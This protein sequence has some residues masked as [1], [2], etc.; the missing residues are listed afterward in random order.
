M[1]LDF[2]SDINK[3]ANYAIVTLA[4]ALATD[5]ALFFIK[6]YIGLSSN[7]L[8]ILSDAIN[9]LSDTFACAIAIVSFAIIKKNNDGRLA[10]GYGR[11]E[12]VADFMM[13]V[14][15]CI[16]G[17]AFVYLAVERLILPSIMIF[18]WL[19]FG[20]VSATALVKVGLGFFFRYRNKRVDSGVLRASEL[21]SFADAGI[22]V[23]S[24]IGFAL[25]R[26]AKLRIDAVFGLIISGIMI[27]NGIKLLIHSV[28]TLL[29]E[30][31]DKEV[32]EEIRELCKA[33]ES[34]EQIREINV[35]RYGA[36]YTELV[37]N[38]VFTSGIN[39]DIIVKDVE[40]LTAVLKEKYGFEPK[41]CISR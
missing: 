38:A 14:I 1:K 32:C 23:M 17:F 35:H 37:V 27:F 13:S 10:Y 5:L 3:R 36:G 6:L 19:Y 28:K 39:Y 2:I 11:M 7:S 12:Y 18:S 25:N 30:K 8:A 29:G 20:I 41:I 9:N 4:V 22:T 31:L 15:I 16:V 40:D 24:L 33:Y 26:Y 21:D 34:V